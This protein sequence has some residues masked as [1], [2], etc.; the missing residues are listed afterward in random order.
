[1]ATQQVPAK[2]T[3][4]PDGAFDART[5]GFSQGVVVDGVLYISGQVSAAAG[6]A[7]QVGEAWAS[8]VEV[9]ETAGGSASSIVKVT[10]FTVDEAAWTHLQPLIEADT[11]PDLPAATMVKVVGLANADLLVE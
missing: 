3:I 2:R 6:L 5:Y 4:Q 11:A 9:V 8:V 10:V 7:S 1:M